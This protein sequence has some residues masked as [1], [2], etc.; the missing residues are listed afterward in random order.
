MARLPGAG[1]PLFG[2]GS[3]GCACVA[4]LFSFVRLPSIMAFRQRVRITVSRSMASA[5][6]G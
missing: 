4:Y 3:S 6:T 2:F 1:V 5:F